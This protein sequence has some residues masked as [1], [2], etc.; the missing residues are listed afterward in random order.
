MPNIFCSYRHEDSMH[1]AGRI[2][3]RLVAS[4]G[5]SKVFRDVDSMPL[6]QDFRQ[7]LSDQVAECDVLLVIIGDAWLNVT[8]PN[9]GGRRLDSPSDFVRIEI[10]SALG[11][12]IPVIPVLVG[13]AHVPQ[14]DELPESLRE[15]SFRHGQAV[16]ADPD[17]NNDIERLIRGINDASKVVAAA[18]RESD[19][20]DDL[21]ER[22]QLYLREVL[23]PAAAEKREKPRKSAPQPLSVAE[24]GPPKSA[25]AVQKEIVPAPPSR[26]ARWVAAVVAVTVIGTLLAFFATRNRR[27]ILDESIAELR[28][29]EVIRDIDSLRRQPTELL[30]AQPSSID[31]ADTLPAVDYSAFEILSDERVV[32][33]R[34]W[35]PVP[36]ERAAELICASSMVRRLRL[37]KIRAADE[38]RF[39]FRTT[40]AQVFVS[41]TSHPKSFRVAGQRDEAFVGGKLTKVRQMTVD[42]SDVPIKGEFNVRLLA[43]YWNSLQKED[44]LWFGAIGYPSSSK[45]SLLIVF[46]DERPFNEYRLMVAPTRKEKPVEYQDR[47]I[48]LASDI[49]DWLYWEIPDPQAGHVYSL[50]WSW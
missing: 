28:R 7:V 23:K 40:G 11:R 21:G 26:R 31:F 24:S 38:I 19:E 39:E 35:K 3:D 29:V 6:G 49:R 17:F 36:P 33:L 50:Y 27:P 41:C 13:R 18:L 30:K 43:T 25:D 8:D 47:K 45:V 48:V 4:F 10:E 20:P 1:Q 9:S 46:P 5:K 12:K 37:R 44:D 22:T 14:P 42:V 34:Q 16:R 2:F 15:L 32:D